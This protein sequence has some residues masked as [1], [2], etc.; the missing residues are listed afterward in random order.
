MGRGGLDEYEAW[1]DTLDARF[2]IG[3]EEIQANFDVPMAVALRDCNDVAGML[4]CALRLREAFLANAAHLPLEYL[5]KRFVRLA[6]QGNRLSVSSAKVISQ[7]PE[8]WNLG[9]K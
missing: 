5:T 2:L 1:L 8:A 6:I 9:S 7:F 3:G 4:K